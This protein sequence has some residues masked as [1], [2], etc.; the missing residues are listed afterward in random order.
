MLSVDDAALVQRDPALPG[1]PLLLD[2]DAFVE[3]L[4]PRLPGLGGAATQYY[5]RYKPETSCLAGYQLQVDGVETEVSARAYRRDGWDKLAKARQQQALGSLRPPLV[6]EDAAVVISL[7]PDDRQ[8]KALARLGDGHTRRELLSR[9]FPQRPDWWD[10]VLRCLR[11]KPERRY[12]AQLL[13]GG[14]PRAVVKFYTQDAY[15]AAAVAAQF[16]RS[17]GSLRLAERLGR[18]LRHRVVACEWLPGVLL[19]EALSA[20]SF[21]LDDLRRVGAALAELH[22]QHSQKLRPITREAE[23]AGLL[24]NASAVGYLCPSLADRVACAAHETAQQLRGLPPGDQAVH[25]DFHAKQVLLQEGTVGVLDLDGAGSGDPALDVG[26][27]IAHLDRNVLSGRLGHEHVALLATSFCEGYRERGC[28]A[29]LDRADLYTAVVLLRLAPHPFRNREPG[30]KDQIAAILDLIDGHLRNGPA[31]TSSVP[32]VSP[33]ACE[34]AAK[35]EDR[36][37]VA[38]DVSMPFLP[39]ALDPAAAY[40]HL[41]A[42]TVRLPGAEL[43]LRLRA[44]RVTRYKPQRRCL[45][46]YELAA[47]G[48]SVTII[49]KARAKGTDRTTY[50]LVETLRQTGF[51]ESAADGVCVPRPLGIVPAWQMWLQEKIAGVAATPLLARAEG[52]RLAHRIAEAI[53]KLHRADVATHRSHTMANEMRIL[54]ERLRDVGLAQPTWAG[55]LERIADACGRLAVSV[56]AADGCGIHRDFY[57]DQVLVGD[58]RLYLLDLDLYCRGDP[59]LDLGNFRAHLI[60]QALRT[61]GHPTALSASEESLTERYLELSGGRLRTAIEVYTTLTL[62]RHI[63]ISTRFPD[64][65]PLTGQLIELCEQRLALSTSIRRPPATG[66]V[67]RG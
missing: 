42:L 23:A 26:N 59:A 51:D 34:T 63:F 4:R 7:F 40:R 55:R 12:V 27:L 17:R 20:E 22:A 18:S 52:P 15:H 32:P 10:G 61:L 25:G 14:E 41:A 58:Q 9:L 66:P 1:L 6:L 47:E 8:L 29:V 43:P 33:P 38:G 48:G 49:G 21:S 5:L 56:P 36:L 37:G 19:D 28:R 13:V 53:H 45:V 60:E 46:E 44:I 11:Y 64:R 3:F 67:K 35:V 30:W 50:R 2:A 39:D 65:S 24:E 31:A 16:L 54:T 62:A 57:P